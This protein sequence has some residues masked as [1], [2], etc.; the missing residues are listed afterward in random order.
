MKGLSGRVLQFIRREALVQGD[1]LLL[2][3]VSGG[4]DSV[5]LLHVLSSLREELNVEL[6]VAHLDHMLRGADSTADA[7][8]V[9]ELARRLS[10]RCTV[11]RR[12]VE[13]YQRTHHMSLEEAA[14]G[15]R[16]D[17]YCRLADWLGAKR[18]VLGHTRDDQVETILMHLIRGAGLA[19]LRGMKPL[20]QRE[21]EGGPVLLVRPLLEV[22][23]AQTQEY[24]QAQGLQPRCDASNYSPAFLRNRLR[25]ELM[26]LLQSYNHNIQDALLRMAGAAHADYS[27]IEEQVSMVWDRAVEEQPGALV[28]DAQ[29][30]TALHP[31]LRRHLLRQVLRRVEGDLTDIESVHVEKMME[32]LSKPAGKELCLPRGVTLHVGY[33][34]CTVTRLDGD[35]CPFAALR[36]EYGL[37]VPGETMLPGWSARAWITTSRETAHGFA[38]SV[39]LDEC[40]TDL[41]VRARKA[42]ERFR[43]LGMAEEKKLQ[44]FMVDAKIPRAWRDRVPLVCSKEGIVW[45]VGW[46]IAHHARVT[47]S[48]R[49]VLHLE[50]E[51]LT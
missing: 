27:Y 18:I 51:K 4:A 28:V 42:G 5:C 39:D 26:P 23:R 20:S 30:V 9:R 11:Q 33:G 34:T 41:I 43:P 15:V 50:F 25:H 47:D 12:D 19:G 46:R 8:Y 45:V 44:D 13:A 17:F 22:T 38:A 3:G 36:G 31:S 48:T 16:Y 35:T 49:R 14:R 6:H 10:V 32:A 21:C 7:E 40:G 24:C 37:K 29:F 2:V 1:E